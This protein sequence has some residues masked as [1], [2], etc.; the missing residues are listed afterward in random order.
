M[1][2][3][4]QKIIDL[5]DLFVEM[6]FRWKI[7][8]CFTIITTLL[9]TC[10]GVWK[11]WKNNNIDSGGT[12]VQEK[13][14]ESKK[15]LTAAESAEVEQ[16]YERYQ[17]YSDYRKQYQ[18]TFSGFLSVS[19]GFVQNAVIKRSTY[20]MSSYIES[21]DA[22]ICSMS[23]GLD[24]YDAIKNI[25]PD[26]ET[27]ED[28]YKY[29]SV[30]SSSS[31]KINVTNMENSDENNH[32][33]YLIFVEVLGNTKE[34]CDQAADV[35]DSAIKREI[36]ELKKVDSEIS[37]NKIG[38]LYRS[39]IIEYIAQKRQVSYDYMNRI[40]TSINNLKVN[41][42]D[43]L[44]G[45]QRQYFNLLNTAAYGEKENTTAQNPEVKPLLNKKMTVLGVLLGVMLSV[46]LVAFK[47]VTN[48]TIKVPAEIEAYY[49]QS[50]IE[51]FFVTNRRKGIFSGII[52]KIYRADTVEKNVKAD[53]VAVDVCGI[54]KKNET[55]SLFIVQTADVETDR[56]I[57]SSI[58]KAIAGCDSNCHPKTG[59]IFE[60]PEQLQKM[61]QFKNALLLVHSRET[62]RSDVE[63][64]LD[65]CKRHAI[66]VAGVVMIIDV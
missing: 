66:N 9:A 29:V 18:K 37:L 41:F 24:D 5:K 14:E 28:A 30:W 49:K 45:N 22:I 26:V 20:V 65:I 27:V 21:A 52:R 8:I 59:L 16:L 36:V 13:L 17:L 56:I 63:K 61:M 40:D 54:M 3:S 38:N 34:I 19:D 31:N 43:K 7:I 32:L 2:S 12:S 62:F 25:L 46:F 15:K 58:T 64:V 50:V 55:D 60:N 4:D 51:S 1:S 57:S 35:V 10:F 44:S 23:L 39:N 11:S 53:L 48:D 33:K 42:I 47:Y 6:L